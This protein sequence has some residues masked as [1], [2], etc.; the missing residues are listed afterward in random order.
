MGAWQMLDMMV[1]GGGYVGLAA[2]VSVKQAAPHLN[3]EVVEAAPAGVWEK[4][5]RAS[6]IIAAASKMLDVLKVWDEILPQSQPINK[7]VVTDS[8]TSDPV[9]PVFLTFDGAV[10][11]GTPFAHMVPNVAMVRALRGAAER[12]GIPIRH[13][14]S[15]TTFVTGSASTI[16]T[17]SDGSTVETRLL[18]ACDGVRSRL[19]D[20]AGIK[21]VSW[22]YGQSGIVATVAHQ[23]PHEGLAEEHFLP[24]G[25][26][27]I[28][29]LPNNQVSL[30]WTER[31]ED[32]DRLVAADDLVFEDE[33]QR[34][35][36]HKLGE[37]AVVGGR[38]AFPLG[39]TLSRAFVAPRFALAGDAAHGI[40]P[41]SGQGLNLGFKD[42]AA[43]AETIVEADRLGLDI[44]SLAIL[45]RY[46]AWRRFDTFRMGVTTDVLNRLF[47]NDVT[48]IRIARD[49]GLG[50]VDRMPKLKNFFIG[51]AAGTTGEGHPK[52]L[53]GQAI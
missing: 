45:E 28:L 11:D 52:L 43:L 5:E 8:R 19:R 29:P 31:T 14:L 2:A 6:A 21:T 34:R 36:G 44:G 38:K 37:L 42:V 10:E 24:S 7:M 20:M 1:V 25:P 18:V 32:A 4:D 50:L 48:P 26:F 49:L 46:Q 40:H 51:Q 16:V 3:I 30:V 53:A 23:R 27:A 15:A 12:L 47:S 35:F 17:L 33:L 13:G 22:K 9:R 39:L 41:I